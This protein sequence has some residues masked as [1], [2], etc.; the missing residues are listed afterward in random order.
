MAYTPELSQIGSATLRRLAWYRRKPM[1]ET[2]ETLMEATARTM[3]EIRPGD[4]C[5][6][7][8]DKSICEECLFRNDRRQGNQKNDAEG[9]TL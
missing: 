9:G 2:L 3:A 7:C 8:Q 6:R 1:T 5:N 4:V